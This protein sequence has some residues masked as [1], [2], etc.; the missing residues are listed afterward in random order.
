[1][2]VFAFAGKPQTSIEIAGDEPRV[3][4]ALRQA[5]AQVAASDG[6]LINLK[7]HKWQTADEFF[8]WLPCAGTTP[9][10]SGGANDLDCIRC[11]YLVPA[12]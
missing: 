6:S 11:C 1:M 7:Q 5:A 2:F 8:V 9:G 10:R 4:R 12:R 3:M